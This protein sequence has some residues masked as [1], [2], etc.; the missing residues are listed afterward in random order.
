MRHP[1]RM[2]A[3][4]PGSCQ[5]RRKTAV[6][7][8]HP[9]APRT[10]SD[11]DTRRL[12]PCLK[13]PSKQLVTAE[14]V[15][16]KQNR[17]VNEDLTVF[18]LAPL[19]TYSGEVQQP[20]APY[21]CPGPGTCTRTGLDESFLMRISSCG[22]AGTEA[23]MV[24]TGGGCHGPQGPGSAHIRAGDVWQ[25][26][27]EGRVNTVSLMISSRALPLALLPRGSHWPALLCHRLAA[28]SRRY[29]SARP[30]EHI[31]TRHSRRYSRHPRA[32]QN[33]SHR[34]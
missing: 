34:G 3:S 32:G 18:L 21:G 8:G 16:R 20:R 15:Q 7:S 33:R 23:G 2:P 26:D 12:T 27:G 10:A 5:S 31:G 1:S 22:S 11:L 19:I 9:R 29:R 28:A 25:R 13:R 17:C 30:R 6:T 24:L 4:V 14:L